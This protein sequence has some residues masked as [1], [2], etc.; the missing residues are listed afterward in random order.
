MDLK[1]IASFSVAHFS[2]NVKVGNTL[3]ELCD[4]THQDTR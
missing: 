3:K 1:K 2:S 4:F